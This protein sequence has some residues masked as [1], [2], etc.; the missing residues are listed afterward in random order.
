MLDCISSPV[1]FG[2]LKGSRVSIHAEKGFAPVLTSY[3][4]SVADVATPRFQTMNVWIND[5]RR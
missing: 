2:H 1:G 5:P 4:F 3:A